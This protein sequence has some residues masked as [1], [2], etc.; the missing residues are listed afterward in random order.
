MHASVELCFKTIITFY[1]K[2]V[3][4]LNSEAF[5]DYDF[6]RESSGFIKKLEFMEEKV[7]WVN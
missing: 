4:Y 7:V 1:L 5:L 6:E 2:N 3:F